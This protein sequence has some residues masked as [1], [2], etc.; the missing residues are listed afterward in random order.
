MATEPKVLYEFGAFQ[1]DPDRQLL[2][3]ENQPVPITP[4][5]FEAL[6]V[7]V[8]RS[9][10]V[11]SK[12]ELM[13]AVWP[14]SFVE[15]AN[16]S[17]NIFRIRKALGGAPG[18]QQYIVTLPGRGY[19]FAAQVRE[20]VL[21]GEDLI[22]GTR[23]H[24]Q[25]VVEQTEL[26]PNE[27]PNTFPATLPP[28]LPP[29]SL[30]KSIWKYALPIASIVAVLVVAAILFLNRHRPKPI[31]LNE[32]DSV[33]LADFTNTTGDPVFDGTLQQGL[34]VQLEQSPFLSLVPEQ[35]V[36][37]TLRMMRQAADARLT[38]E[39]AREVCERIGSAAVLD[40]SIAKLG[41]QYVLGLRA[42][43]CRTGEL[44][45]DEQVQAARK[46]DV[47]NALSQIASRLRTR[48]GESLAT[49][50]KHNTPLAEATTP[51]LEALKAYSAAHK[52]NISSGIA[53]AVPF[54]Q[55]TIEID[56]EFAM[57]YAMLGLVYKRLGE[58]V[59]AAENATKAYELRTRASDPEKFLITA[60]YHRQV[61]GNLEKGHQTLE[62]WVETYPRD[63][64]A[65]A[66]LAGYCSQ[67]LGKYD[68]VLE[69][70]RKTIE[71]DPDYTFAYDEIASS[72]FRLDHPQEAEKA[73][74]RASERNLDNPDLLMLRY[75]AAFLRGDQDGMD[76]EMAR[77]KGKP[78]AED[79][80]SHAEAL[81]LAR[82]GQVQRAKEMS[83]RAVDLAQQAGQRE[84]AAV[85]ETGPAVWEAFYGNATA[86]RR[87]AAAALE[88][89]RGRDVEYGAAF[90]L[91]LAGDASRSQA[92]ANDLERRFPEDTSVRFA[93]VPTLR[94]L[95]ALN[96]GEPAKA[97]EALQIAGPYELAISAID[98]E[99]Y[100]GALYSA[101]VRGSAYLAMHRG[102]EAATEFQKILDHRG[103]VISDPV[104]A[105]AH[106]QLGRAYVLSGDKTKGRIAYHDFLTL[107]KDADP[108]ISLLKQAKAEY[109]KLN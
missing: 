3:R 91:A 103:I 67:G 86:A 29:G 81:H 28:P 74:Q 37:Q 89:S 14:D 42:R 94:A 90:A 32:T 104:G 64:N 83:R 40:G 35:R 11:V 96:R 56:P 107:W 106:L 63:A 79:L 49:V 98:F 12:D 52:I 34:E 87:D 72:Y 13:K 18:D 16:L 15:E 21:D 59:L 6:L 33:L 54:Y 31:A 53:A 25:I 38:P 2:L 51:S 44:L 61:T 62:L 45:A 27:T 68:Q 108:D 48:V 80:I 23:S 10:E 102:S 24:T 20:V 75:F 30:P 71:L 7:L 100:F 66:L 92:L 8:R 58:S 60:M 73:L 101:Y 78:G 95:L 36:Q 50:E 55:R 82:S 109:A 47:L 17:Q 97:M 57:A 46:E 19:R 41:S 65:H 84:R 85:F 77:A 22:I 26:A 76:R 69:E 9:R 39:I 43:N 105:L 1:V 93:Y 5:A 4:K 70:G 88:L 99:F